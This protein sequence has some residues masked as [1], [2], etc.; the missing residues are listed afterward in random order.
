[1]R[2]EESVERLADIFRYALSA[3][4]KEFVTLRDELEFIDSYLEI[5][6]ARFGERLEVT[7]AISP[8][9]LNTIIPGLILQPLVENS[10]KHG[11]GEN[12]KMRITI[13][14]HMDGELVQLA[15]RDEG[16]GVPDQIRKGVYTSGTGLRNVSERL[17]RVYGEGYGL[18]IKETTPNGT[19]A[20]VTIPR[21][22]K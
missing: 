6:K 12:G 9:I 10:I 19:T 7:R 16:R 21:E 13:T 3:S 17:S 4:E 20:T 22:K 18:E 8:D 11:S 1:L 2:A 5:E 14:G 15:I